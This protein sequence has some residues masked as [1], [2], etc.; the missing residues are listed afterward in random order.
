MLLHSRRSFGSVGSKD[1]ALFLSVLWA[2]ESLVSHRCLKVHFSFEG[3]AL[4][5]AINRPKAWPSFKF[6]VTEIR[7][8]LGNFLEWKV[9][10]ESFAANRGARLI[11]QSAVKDRWF[12]SYVALGH[13]R[14][15]VNGF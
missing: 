3:S 10:F 1:E 13:P 5:N 11:A 9:F 6:K 4:V 15:L 8:I 12:Q 7:Y 2:M 14:W